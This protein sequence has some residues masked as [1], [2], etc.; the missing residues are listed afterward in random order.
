MLVIR[1]TD[2]ARLLVS[3]KRHSRVVDSESDAR[4]TL[5]SWGHTDIS[6]NKALT[7]LR[8]AEG[9]AGGPA[10]AWRVVRPA[11]ATPETAAAPE[12]AAEPAAEKAPAKRTRKPRKAAAPAT[13]PRP[14]P[15]PAAEAAP[16]PG[17]KKPRAPRKRAG[18]AKV[19]AAPAAKAEEAAPPAPAE[20]KPRVP[21]KRA[22]K[23]ATGEA[24]PAADPRARA[25][26]L[27]TQLSD[28]LRALENDTLPFA[29][30]PWADLRGKAEYIAACLR[31]KKPSAAAAKGD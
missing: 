9:S 14:A 19:E 3:N 22:A 20:R 8:R 23:A 21:R 28:A 16:A 2:D 29:R 31:G 10:H 27:A 18:K 30:G 1:R 26:D 11:A 12:P 17:A 15:V 5:Y 13:P 6:I 24:A 4:R 25:V 7:E